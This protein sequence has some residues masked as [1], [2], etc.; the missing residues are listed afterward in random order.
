M[1]IARCGWWM[2]CLCALSGCRTPLSSKGSANAV[3]TP[4]QDASVSLNRLRPD[5]YAFSFYSDLRKKM[6]RVVETRSEWNALWRRICNSC[7]ADPLKDL[8]FRRQKVIVSALGQR[9]TGGFGILLESAHVRTGRVEIVV[10]EI[11]PAS[12]CVLTMATSQPVDVAII[13]RT[14]KRIVFRH[15][16]TVTDCG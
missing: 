2:I 1:S 6:D 15:Y 9:N 16:F 4:P 14:D 13:P 8:D 3:E 7:E 11:A 5:P 12:S 10:R